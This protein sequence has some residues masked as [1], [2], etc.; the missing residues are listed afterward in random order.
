MLFCRSWKP[1][2]GTSLAVIILAGMPF[3]AGYA[4]ENGVSVYPVGVE[5]VMPAMLPGPGQS[6]LLEFNDFYQANALVD[7]SGHSLVPGFHLRV[8]AVA[9]KFVHNWKVRALGG[10]LVSSAAV[11]FLYEHLDGPFGKF[12][13]RGVGNPDIGVLYVAYGKG[14]WHWYYGMDAFTP[15]AEYN[16]SDLLNVGQHNFAAAPSAAF[17]YLP[18]HGQSELSSRFQYIVNFTNPANEYRSGHE[19]VWEYTAM[20]NVVG[21]LALGLN[22]RYYQQMT[23]DLQNG[24]C[25]GTGNR[26]RSVA[27][28]PQ[29]RYHLGRAALILKFQREMLVEN[30]AA[31]NAFWFQLGVPVGRHE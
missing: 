31:G 10:T 3:T 20:R 1:V 4:T 7:G 27:M 14:P 2:Y 28:G 30:R 29:A 11:P 17:T 26:G 13:K 5:T 25:V 23:D 15:G 6:L 12:D 9:F 22:G 24:I 16:K 19:F 8:G 18:N 21:K